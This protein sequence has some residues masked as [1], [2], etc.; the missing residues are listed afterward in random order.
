MKTVGIFEAKRYLSALLERVE[1]GEEIVITR[2][3][4]PIASLVPVGAVSYDRLATAVTR[5]KA[6][7]RG[8]RLGNLSPKALIEEGRR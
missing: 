8:R 5:L 7:R 2:R 3:G 6:F 4:K 1:R